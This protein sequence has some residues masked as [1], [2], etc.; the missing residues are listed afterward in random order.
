MRLIDTHCHLNDR[1][2]FPNPA[3]VIDEA[4]AAGVEKLVV[5]GVDTESSRDA[6]NLAD[7]F[8]VVYA[9]VGW[10]PTHTHEY[11]RDE[12]KV[13]ES[14]LS[15]PK[16]VA[17]GE[18]GLD[19]HWDYS[20]PEQQFIALQD[21]LDVAKEYSKPIVFHCREA[22]EHLLDFLERRENDPPYLFHCFAGDSQIAKRCL[23]LG[24][25]FGVDGPITY[26]S[27]DRLREVILG[28]GLDRLVVETDA[29]WMTP[30]PHRGQR[31]KPAWVAH[32]N[33][34]LA[35]LFEVSPEEC[36]EITTRNAEAFFQF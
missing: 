11:S 19:F 7:E 23:D 17:L 12:L 34:G 26:K 8:E 33:E 5:V 30:V 27:A 35:S 10:H 4:L 6:V 31:N 1:K 25:M 3:S 9:V 13:V 36:A 14:L 18:I 22:E 16:V 2:A 28:I 15:H 32:V 21:Q 24:G 20:T 29:P